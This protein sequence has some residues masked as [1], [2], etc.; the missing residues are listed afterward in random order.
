MRNNNIEIMGTPCVSNKENK[1]KNNNQ[2]KENERKFSFGDSGNNQI[3]T[4]KKEVR[5]ANKKTKIFKN[6]EKNIEYKIKRICGKG[7]YTKVYQCYKLNDNP[8]KFY[9]LKTISKKI[10]K[11]NPDN[12]SIEHMEKELEF[13]KSLKSKYIIEIIDNFNI[14]IE[15]NIKRPFIIYPYYN[16]DLFTLIKQTNKNIP[17]KFIKLILHD[18]YVS[19]SY[20]HKEK[21][22]YRDLKPENI[23]I[24]LNEGRCILIDFGLSIKVN[25]KDE[26]S[27]LCGTNQYIPPEVILGEKYNFDFDYW[28]FGIFCYEIVYGFP[29]FRGNNQKEIFDNIIECNINFSKKENLSNEIEDLIIYLLKKE[30]EE[31]MEWINIPYHPFFKGLDFNMNNLNDN[32]NQRNEFKS[33]LNKYKNTFYFL[34]DDHN[35][36]K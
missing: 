30:K 3:N 25:E 34:I 16:L 1:E 13:L 9:A 31:R 26:L 10:L 15:N 6:E 18:V 14:T 7:F 32:L 29:P 23:V 12:K 17:L 35:I 8:N 19:L 2:I 21:I 33:F 36:K 28:T 5:N 22:I 11:A 24:D 27:E 4:E 20:L